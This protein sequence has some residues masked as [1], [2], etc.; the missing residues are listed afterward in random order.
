LTIPYSA[1]NPDIEVGRHAVSIDERRAFFRQNL[2]KPALPPKASGP[3]NVKQVWFAGVHCDV[4]GGYPPDEDGLSM[5]T[6]RWMLR[7]S[8]S[9]GLRVDPAKEAAVLGAIPADPGAQLHNSLTP[10]WWIGEL[11]PKPHWDMSKDPPK[12]G[13]RM[14]LW[15][16]RIIP[17]ESVIHETVLQR[18]KMPEKKYHPK[19][20]RGYQVES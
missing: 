9:A 3:R 11:I 14:N 17:E 12:E 1:N 15:R 19:L 2:W 7:E 18:M 20:P 6:L 10:P 13:L 8:K 16:R 4:G 5:I